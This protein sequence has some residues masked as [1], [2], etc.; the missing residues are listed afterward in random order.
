M[1]VYLCIM[2][3][4]LVFVQYKYPVEKLDSCILKIS[5]WDYK[6]FGRNH[7]IGEMCI[8][9]SSIVK[10]APYDSWHTLCQGMSSDSKPAYQIKLPL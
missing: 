1:F 2:S 3:V 7:C 6:Q 8:P 5:L 10:A 9:F 4:C